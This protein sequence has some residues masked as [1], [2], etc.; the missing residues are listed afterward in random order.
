[1]CEHIHGISELAGEWKQ[2][3]CPPQGLVDRTWLIPV[4]QDI[5]SLQKRKAI[6]KDDAE[7][8]G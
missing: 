2:L 8:A 4:V 1:M 6:H 5:I 7:P 3:E